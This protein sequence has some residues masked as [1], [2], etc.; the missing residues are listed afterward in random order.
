MLE[1]HLRNIPGLLWKSAYAMFRWLEALAAPPFQIFRDFI[2][3]GFRVLS[4]VQHGTKSRLTDGGSTTKPPNLGNILCHLLGK[5]VQR[6]SWRDTVSGRLM[7]LISIAA[8]LPYSQG[9]RTIRPLTPKTILWKYELTSKTPRPSP[10]GTW[11]R[12]GILF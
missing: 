5:H 12:T 4:E 2:A 10:A 3:V 6:K 11:T 7:R 9:S 8:L 1:L